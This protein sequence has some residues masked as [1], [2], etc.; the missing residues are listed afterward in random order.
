MAAAL[1]DAEVIYQEADAA[2][3]QLLGRSGGALRAMWQAKLPATTKPAAPPAREDLLINL[4]GE[5]AGVAL[6]RNT[7]RSLFPR[8]SGAT[9]AQQLS[10]KPLLSR[11]TTRTSESTGGEADLSAS[12]A[13]AIVPRRRLLRD[14]DSLA[15]RIETFAKR[16][17]SRRKQRDRDAMEATYG[18]AR[19]RLLARTARSRARSRVDRE[20][21]VL[22]EKLRT[23]RIAPEDYWEA[24][25]IARIR[26][27]RA[28]YASFADKPASNLTRPPGRKQAVRK[29]S[30]QASRQR[31]LRS[32]N[33]SRAHHARN[34]TSTPEG[35]VRRLATILH[36]RDERLGVRQLLLQDSK[37][38]VQVPDPSSAP[39]PGG[40]KR[41]KTRRDASLVDESVDKT[42]AA[43][44]A[45]GQVPPQQPWN[46]PSSSSFVP[47]ERLSRKA[48]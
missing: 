3:S 5:L 35:E 26:R 28:L 41:K 4:D 17:A 2:C 22:V 38:P 11:P 27:D 19:S 1:A 9:S 34:D 44:R 7:L 40:R 6:L 39:R 12:R 20:R 14:S 37:T 29:R 18:R 10:S 15:R 46:P 45:D 36:A 16:Y 8:S 24:G 30:R 47:S 31:Q 42:S 25:M 33:R 32:A 13:I 48:R 23:N 43:V 21:Q